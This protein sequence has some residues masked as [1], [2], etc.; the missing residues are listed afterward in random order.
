MLEAL[1]GIILIGIIIGAVFIYSTLSW[2]LVLFK[3][4]GWFVLPTFTSLPELSFVQALGLMF[5][6]SLFK[7]MNTEIIKKEYKEQHA[8]AIMA[9][10]SPWISLFFGWVAYSIWLV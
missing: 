5:V 3:F 7:S 4:W 6:V 10:V 1:L 8:G 2:G 9:L